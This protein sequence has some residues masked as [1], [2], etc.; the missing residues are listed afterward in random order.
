VREAR[1]RRDAVLAVGITL[2]NVDG[3]EFDRLLAPLLPAD[4]QQPADKHATV[5][6]GVLDAA[7][8][9]TLRER[10]QGGKA[11]LL[12]TP[13]LAVRPL[14]P[15]SISSMQETSYVKDFTVTKADTSFVAEP[16]ADVVRDGV[17]IDLVATFTGKD[18]LG[19]LCTLTKVDLV[20]P[21]PKFSTTIAGS[22]LPVT[23]ELPEVRTIRLQQTADLPPGG[24]AVIAAPKA[25]GSWLVA[26]VQATVQK[27]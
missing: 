7:A 4:T 19:V 1:R 20:R 5:R 22:T 11:Q 15:A 8:T 25:D 24:C 14:E 27:Q 21:I 17:R 2:W 3:K 12:E 26:L 13:T 16:V 6:R 9:A 23:I 10:M 18:H